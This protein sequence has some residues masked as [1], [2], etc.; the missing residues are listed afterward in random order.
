MTRADG[1]PTT[2]ESTACGLCTGADPS[3][4]SPLAA[5]LGPGQSRF[6]A[7]T[8]HFV[9]VP[10]YGSFVAGY[11]LIVPRAHVLSFG[12]LDAGLLDEAQALMDSLAGR[13]Q[14][15]YELPVLGFEYGINTRGVRRI[16]HAHWHLLPSQADLRTWLSERLA[17]RRITSLA[18]LRRT[19]GSYIA[20]RGQDAALTAYEV[21]GSLQGDERIRLRRTVAALDARVGDAAWD[22]VDHLG[23]E[24]IR[25]TVADLAA[26]DE[27]VARGQ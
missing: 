5:L 11:L 27:A 10:T 4:R 20:V 18:G 15:V 16:E 2:G 19:E 12:R 17:G 9:A 1:K 26:T 21:D 7:A 13:L 24:L 8:P 14:A 6:I 23:V 25:A 3:V 22:W